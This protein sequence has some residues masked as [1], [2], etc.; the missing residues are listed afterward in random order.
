M[1]GEFGGVE[2]VHA[3]LAVQETIH[4][5]CI[6]KHPDGKAQQ[7]ITLSPQRWQSTSAK[8]R[9]LVVTAGVIAAPADSGG[10]RKPS[11]RRGDTRSRAVPCV[12]LRCAGVE[13]GYAGFSP[14]SRVNTQVSPCA[15]SSE[16]QIVGG[17]MKLSPRWI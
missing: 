13:R 14:H 17:T 1:F 7:S 2:L 6:A 15:L 8:S 16:L 11:G 10:E 9:M 12:C 4:S 3:S 5:S